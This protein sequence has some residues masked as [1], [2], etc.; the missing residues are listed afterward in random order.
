[1]KTLHAHHMTTIGLIAGD[2]TSEAT[3]LAVGDVS[4]AMFKEGGHPGNLFAYVPLGGDATVMKALGLS[5]KALAATFAQAPAMRDLLLEMEGRI[6]A[7]S[8]LCGAVQ[9][10]DTAA[11]WELLDGFREMIGATLGKRGPVEDEARR[12]CVLN[13][14]NAAVQVQADR[15]T[16]TVKRADDGVSV[17]V[18]GPDGG[19]ITSTWALFSDAAD[20][21]EREAA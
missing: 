21:F 9:Y 20:G 18:T 4:E 11:V 17:Y 5:P 15:L 10:T 16:V 8:D 19:D 1:M 3:C 2:P 12:H 13:E 14:P 7:F 6:A